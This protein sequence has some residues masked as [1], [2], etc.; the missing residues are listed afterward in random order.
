MHD[1]TFHRTLLRR[2]SAAFAFMLL[3]AVVSASFAHKSH[4]TR[5]S[6]FNVGL[7]AY[8]FPDGSV[9]VICFGTG[10]H[11]ER[12]S[13]PVESCPFC[14]LCKLVMLPSPPGTSLLAPLG[15]AVVF[16]GQHTLLPLP[17]AGGGFRS[18]APPLSA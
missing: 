8:S 16:S 18:R 9:P 12:E 11:D 3:L 17:Y 7:A 13:A 1:G 14:T 10:E 5:S 6:G 2:L 15:F 4:A